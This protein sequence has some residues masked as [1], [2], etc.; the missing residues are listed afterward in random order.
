M[1]TPIAATPFRVLKDVRHRLRGNGNRAKCGHSGLNRQLSKLEHT[2]LDSRWNT[3]EQYFLIKPKSGRMERYCF[4]KIGFVFIPKLSTVRQPHRK[5]AKLKSKSRPFDTHME[6]ENKNGISA[7]VHK[8]GN[9]RNHH[10]TG[11]CC[12]APA[13]WM[14]PHRKDR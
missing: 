6:A 7:D 4:T 5:Y 11:G 10:R 1:P 3:D 8:V 2:V 14:R 12:S 13:E 9:H